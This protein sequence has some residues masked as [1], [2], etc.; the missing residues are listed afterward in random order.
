MGD[1][2]GLFYEYPSGASYGDPHIMGAAERTY[3]MPWAPAGLLAGGRTLYWEV[4]V[5]NTSFYRVKNFTV[6][7]RYY[8]LV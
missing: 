8:V 2:A 1:Y 3:S 5:I 4:L 7:W 6:R